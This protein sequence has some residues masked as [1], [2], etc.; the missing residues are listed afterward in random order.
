M[1][2]IYIHLFL[3]HFV[4]KVIHVNVIFIYPE[5]LIYIVYGYASQAN[6]VYHANSSHA[7]AC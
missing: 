7:F 6:A 2:Q 5:D 1:I 4:F 3:C